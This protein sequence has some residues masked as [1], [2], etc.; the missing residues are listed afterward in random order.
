MFNRYKRIDKDIKKMAHEKARAASTMAESRTLTPSESILSY[1]HMTM[2]GSM[3]SIKTDKR[4][5]NSPKNKLRLSQATKG[6]RNSINYKTLN[7]SYWQF[8]C[9]D[10]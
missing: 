6:H 1:E 10:F 2:R 7:P 9:K 3:P 5:N 4:Y 8:K